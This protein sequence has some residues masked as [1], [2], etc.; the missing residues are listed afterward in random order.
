MTD[1]KETSAFAEYKVFWI[2]NEENKYK[3]HISKYSGNA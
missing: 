1:A 3:L 2:E